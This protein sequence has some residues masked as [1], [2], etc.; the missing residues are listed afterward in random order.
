[1]EKSVYRAKCILLKNVEIIWLYGD[2][3]GKGSPKQ[4]LMF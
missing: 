4:I 3:A 1:M 2:E